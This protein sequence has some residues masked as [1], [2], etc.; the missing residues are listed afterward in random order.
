VHRRLAQFTLSAQPAALP[1]EL[2]AAG[3][4][5]GRITSTALFNGARYGLGIVRADI[6]EREPSLDYSGGTATLVPHPPLA[7][8]PAQP[9]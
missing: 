4:A 7:R 9:L 6:V 5:A 1:V 2:T 3:A 8:T